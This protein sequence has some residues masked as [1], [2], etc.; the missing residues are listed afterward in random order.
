MSQTSQHSIPSP[1]TSIFDITLAGVPA[2]EVEQ[3][4]EESVVENSLPRAR[5][6]VFDTTLTDIHAPREAKVFGGF[7]NRIFKPKIAP[8]LPEGSESIANPEE[9]VV[10]IKTAK[11]S[12]PQ[13][14]KVSIFDITLAGVPEAAELPTPNPI[15]K[16]VLESQECEA[17]A[18]SSVSKDGHADTTLYC[19]A[20]KFQVTELPAEVLSPTPQTAILPELEEPTPV[21]AMVQPEPQSVLAPDPDDWDEGTAAEWNPRWSQKLAPL[22]ESIAEP[23]A[24]VQPKVRSRRPLL[25]GGIALSAA[26][27]LGAGLFFRIQSHEAPPVKAIPASL[28]SYKI[29]ADAGDPVAMR[30]LGLCIC[31]GVAGPA[32]WSEGTTWLR[33]AAKSGDLTAKT[34]L[35]SMGVRL[36]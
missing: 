20:E 28:Q 9:P 24:T 23:E 26:T 14:P 30:M 35:T 33:R 5:A 21:I 6:S 13:R 1:K 16:A 27:I 19:E 25:I 31:Y 22:A 2:T 17:D 32:D 29:R 4:H 3:Q 12:M 11:L 15:L 34:E 7:L 36:D 10:A 18:T 8:V